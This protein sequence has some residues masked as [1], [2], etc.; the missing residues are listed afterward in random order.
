MS[1]SSLTFAH[2]LGHNLGAKHSFGDT[3][4]NGDTDLNS[5]RY[6]LRFESAGGTKYRTIMAYSETYGGSRIPHYANPNV[7]F[8]GTPT[9]L[10]DGVDLAGNTLVDPVY[11]G[12]GFDGSNPN[13]GARNAEMFLIQ[14]GS[15]GVVFAS[16]RS[17]RTVLGITS[18]TVGVQWAAGSSQIIGFTGGDM[19]YTAD[20]DLYKGGVYQETLANDINATN[21]YFNWN[22]PLAQDGGN[23]YQIRVTLTHTITLVTSSTMSGF[24]VIQG[25]NDIILESPIG[26]ETW[27]RNNN[28]NITWSSS[29]G[30][31]VK[32]ELKKGAATPVTIINSTPDDGSYEWTIPFD[33]TL[34]GDYRI[35]ITSDVSPFDTSQSAGNFTIG[36]PS[37]DILVTNLDTD[38]GFTTSGDFEYGVPGAGNG[39][40]ASYTGTKMYDTELNATSYDTSSLTTYALDCSNHTNI[41]LD[42][43]AYILIYDNYTA[44]FEISTDNA[45]WID[46]ET[47]G[48]GSQIDQ[49]WTNYTYDITEYAAG[50]PTVYIRWS[51]L[52]SG[53]QYLGGGLSIDDISITGDF[54]PADGFS[55]TSPNG[56]E[57]FNTE[58][59]KPITWLSELGG[60]ARIEL[61]KNGSVHTTIA[62]S[63]PNDGVFYWL[64]PDTLATASDYKIRITSVENGTKVD[65]SDSNFA[66]SALT[67]TIF[68]S[69]LDT[70]PG[71]SVSGE[72]EFGA[73][74]G[75]NIASPPHTGS[76]MYDTDLDDTATNGSL[77]TMALD[78]SAH[79][80][81]SLNFWAHR[82]INEGYTVRFE[83]SNDN[84]NWIELHSIPGFATSTSSDY[85]WKEFTYDISSV[86]DLQST[87][88]IRWSLSGSGTYWFGQGLAIDDISIT[89]TVTP[90]SPTYDTWA[91]GPASDADSNVDGISNAIAWVLGA[92]SPAANAT[93]LQPT[94]DNLT[95]PG[96]MIFTYRRADQANNDPNT[97][98]LVEYGSDLAGWTTA[99]DSG[100]TVIITEDDDFF[101]SGID[102][103]QVK[104]KKT[105]AI[106][107][108]MFSRLKVLVIE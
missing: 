10:N 88:Y 28:K 71:F 64:L 101:G 49:P 99:T 59:L 22:I 52:G 1:S 102:R 81:V 3:T 24:F 29:Y 57:S 92:A 103:V 21:R 107:D 100:D 65:E 53:T 7:D 83:V 61:L 41:I 30:G 48:V 56:G 6:G 77:T 14:S 67:S 93:S 72:F 40:S 90:A 82:F 63:T 58:T 32:I 33:Q 108:R 20:I 4:R 46:L 5:A 66:I 47:L 84:T 75:N 11:E 73:P 70:D 17:I 39:A 76:N 8:D 105:L 36:A 34:D 50:E 27:T 15:N 51:M 86:A 18:P 31:N 23:N 68:S 96:Y 45:T 87:V 78:C 12:F 95:A 62:N 35:I 55:I 9:G 38:P 60:N 91:Q 25:V 80:N 44:V 79:T 42:F 106:D 16:N 94:I 74:A 19:E 43:W 54:I 104:I 85:Q 69:N 37:N 98:I 26:G 13:L 97:T 2:E 89:G